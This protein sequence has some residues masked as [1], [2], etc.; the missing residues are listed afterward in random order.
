[1]R[2]CSHVAVFHCSG[3]LS[4]LRARGT[5]NIQKTATAGSAV[6]LR[7]GEPFML[8][9]GLTLR[10]DEL[11][12][13]ITP[14]YYVEAHSCIYPRLSGQ[15]YVRGYRCACRSVFP[16]HRVRCGG[17]HTRLSF[18]VWG[19]FPRYEGEERRTF[20]RRQRQAAQ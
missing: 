18:I 5:P 3:F 8:R 16:W 12:N 6:N 15:L 4:A 9:A 19:S 1:M 7:R 13:G 20:K 10:G 17:A 14:G 11:W 2:R